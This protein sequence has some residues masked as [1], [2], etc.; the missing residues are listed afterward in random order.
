M[1]ENVKT[2][3]NILKNLSCILHRSHKRKILLVLPVLITSS[4]LELLGVTAILPFVQA[5]ITPEKLFVNQNIRKIATVFGIET[6]KQLVLGIGV[7]IIFVYLFKNIFMIFSYYVQYSFASCVQRDLS[8]DLFKAFLKKPYTFFLNINSAEIHRSCT[9]DTQNVNNMITFLFGI[10]TEGLSLLLICVFIF[11][12]DMFIAIGTLLLLCLVLIGMI[13]F[14]KPYAKYA[15]KVY[16]EAEANRSKVLYQTVSGIKEIFVMRRNQIFIKNYLKAT[17]ESCKAQ[18][19]NNLVTNCPERIIEG[20]CVSGLIGI[21][22]FRLYFNDDML[23]FVPKLATF[24]MAAF[25]MFPAIGKITSRINGLMFAKPSLDNMVRVISFNRKQEIEGLVYENVG[26]TTNNIEKIHFKDTLEVSDICWKY[27]NQSPYVLSNA[28]ME[29]K[30]GQAVALVGS[31]GAG[32]TTLA[33]IILG[34]LRPQNGYVR[35]DGIDVQLMPEEWASIIGYVPQVVFL[36][37]DSIRNN[38]AFGIEE[39]EVDDKKIW[40]A[41]ERAQLKEFVESLPDKLDTI[42]GE[43]GVRFSG[44]QRQRIAIARALYSEPEILILDEATAALDKETEAAVME[45]IEALHGKVTLIIVAHRMTTIRKCD[46]IYEVGNGSVTK[47]DKQQ[48]WK[49]QEKDNAIQS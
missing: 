32:K 13:F 12:T 24:A 18:R 40:E 48:F 8:V 36:L 46:A 19:T 42:V 26:K 37:D 15:G 21:V 6:S 7:G 1:I 41:L 38:I 34:L 27:D 20:I 2:I 14:F 23:S 43:R 35:M 11:Y 45:S 5:V 31:S 30:L 9:I 29:V 49:E 39:M 47:L 16:R 17:N 3:C 10:S 25:K 4:L 44:G 22:C 33:D 28:S